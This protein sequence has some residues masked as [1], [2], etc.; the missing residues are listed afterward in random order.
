M[1]LAATGSL[2]TDAVQL[3]YE[4]VDT[5]LRDVA[6]ILDSTDV[7]R[8]DEIDVALSLIDERREKGP[9]S[10]YYFVFAERDGQTCGYA[11]YGPVPLTA[12]SYDIYW[13][14][15]AKS[16]QGRRLGRTLLFEAER[17]VR[18]NGGRRIYIET[19]SR[20]C[21]APT[22]EFYLRCGYRHEAT[23]DDFYAPG[24]AKVVY[25]KVF[26]P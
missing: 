18:R 21:Y 24:D 1:R 26:D 23:L 20:A 25:V 3:R 9:A 8:A 16:Q 13:I 7:F 11:C 6:S 14:A 15:V 22:R 4:P 10:G 2:I 5:D 17:L 12:S 19:S